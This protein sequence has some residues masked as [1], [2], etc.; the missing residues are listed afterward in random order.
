M[1][2]RGLRL[3]RVRLRGVVHH[4]VHLVVVVMVVGDE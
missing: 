2:P 1:L 4:V 3:V